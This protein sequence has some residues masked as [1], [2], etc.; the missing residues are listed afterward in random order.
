MIIDHRMNQLKRY[1][2]QFG[3]PV[4][5]GCVYVPEAYSESYNN[6]S[7]YMYTTLFLLYTSI[8]SN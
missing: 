4:D 2:L 6:W 5:Q 3:A 7:G 8:K 1:L